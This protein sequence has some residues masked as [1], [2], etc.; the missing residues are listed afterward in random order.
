MKIVNQ[1]FIMQNR[2]R[3][4]V[5]QSINSMIERNPDLTGDKAY[6]LYY[7]VKTDYDMILNSLLNYDVNSDFLGFPNQ[8]QVLRHQIE[9]FLD[10]FNLA[11]DR[12]Y[13]A[14]LKKNNQ[15]DV[16]LGIYEEYLGKGSF[17]NIKQK[18]KIAKRNGFP[19]GSYLEGFAKNSNRYVHPNV[20]IE[21]SRQ[22]AKEKLLRNL[23]NVSIFLV[24]EAYKVMTGILANR[25]LQPRM[26]CENCDR[27][28][29]DCKGCLGDLV[30]DDRFFVDTSEDLFTEY[31][32][33]EYSLWDSY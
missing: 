3:G 5:E 19:Y 32:P 29:M 18:L 2:V 4:F 14:V 20:F 7:Y 11:S 10:L 30:T 12:A 24:V 15:E 23:I 9:A 22:E 6:W 28:A 16:P 25:G 13:M 17:Y 21:T 8:Q 1:Q 26:D 31:D 27:E 33:Q